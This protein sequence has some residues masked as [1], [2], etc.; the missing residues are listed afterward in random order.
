MM[1]E[2]V[3]TELASISTYSASLYHW[4]VLLQKSIY[5]PEYSGC[6]L[7]LF[8]C[9]TLGAMYP[10]TWLRATNYQ[11][12]WRCYG[13]LLYWQGLHERPSLPIGLV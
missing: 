1:I 3:E 4:H 10:V 2:K 11:G 12:L 5:T 13:H 6:L 9:L 8:G 7:S